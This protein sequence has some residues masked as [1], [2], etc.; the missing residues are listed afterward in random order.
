VLSRRGPAPDL[1]V[2]SYLCASLEAFYPAD[3]QTAAALQ[4]SCDARFRAKKPVKALRASGDASRTLNSS[5]VLR[6]ERRLCP[7]QLFPYSGRLTL[8]RRSCAHLG[9]LSSRRAAVQGVTL[10]KAACASN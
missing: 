6:P 8:L 10:A 1:T 7:G 2:S 9:A 5:A 4:G 3:A